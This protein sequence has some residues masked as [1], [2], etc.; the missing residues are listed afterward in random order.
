MVNPRTKTHRVLRQSLFR[1]VV[2]NR[3][4]IYEVRGIDGDINDK[5]DFKFI[6]QLSRMVKTNSNWKQ[7]LDFQGGRPTQLDA[8]IPVKSSLV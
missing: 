2:Y 8:E 7:N 5:I 3:P 6:G 4:W 1:G